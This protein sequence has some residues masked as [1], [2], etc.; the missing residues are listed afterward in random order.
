MA[1]KAG[2]LGRVGWLAA[3]VGPLGIAI[4]VWRHVATH[5]VAVTVVIGLAYAGVVAV[6]KFAAGIIRVLAARWRDQL[7][8]SLDVALQRRISRFGRRYRQFVLAGLRFTD[9]KGLATVGPFTPELD[10]VFVDVSLVSRPPHKI[11]PGLLDD[12]VVDAAGRHPLDD[13]INRPVPAVLAV[14]GGPGSGKTTLLRHTARDVCLKRTRSKARKRRL[15]VLLYLRDHVA[16]IVANPDVSI[17]DLIRSTLGELK[18]GEPKGW[19]EER[20]GSGECVVLLD[21]LDEVARQEDRTRVATWA[22]RQIRQHPGNDYV[23]T[24]RPYGYRVA[25]VAGAHVLAVC[26]LTDVQIDRFVHRWY[27]AVE[28]HSTGARDES[29]TARA[30][31]EADDLLRRLEEVPALRDLTVNPLLLTMI[32][33]VHR[34][35]GALPGSRAELYAEICQVM[36]WRRQEAKNLP[37]NLAGDKKEQ[38]LRGLA[39]AMMERRV[40][41]LA[42]GDVLAEIRPALRRLAG[43]ITAEDFLADV[44][45]NGLL[46]ERD[47]ELYCFV[48]PTFQEYLAAAHIRDK[49]LVRVL[50]DAVSDPWWREATL[51]YA[52]HADADP[53]IKA[54]LSSDSVIALALAFDCADQDSEIAVDLREQLD[55]MLAAVSRPDTTSERRRLIAGVLLTRHLHDQ[56]RTRDGRRICVRPITAD[57]YQ[58]FLDDT[59]TPAPDTRPGDVAT[60]MAVGMRASDAA[61]FVQWANAVT[62]GATT[63]NLPG[64]S[65]LRDP[66]V[67]ELLFAGSH[68]IQVSAVWIQSDRIL[69]PADRTTP[70]AQRN[71]PGPDLFIAGKQHPYRID[72][73]MLASYLYGDI[74]QS[75]RMLGRILAIRSAVGVITLAAYLERV[76]GQGVA[77]DLNTLN[78][79]RGRACVRDLDVLR[80]LAIGRDLGFARG[81]HP[82]V[83]HVSDLEIAKELELALNRPLT[84]D[85][86]CLTP[87]HDCALDLA[88][89]LTGRLDADVIF[90]TD[91]YRILY[92]T[93]ALDTTLSRALDI[94][95]D[96]GFV[97]ARVMGRALSKALSVTLRTSTAQW[98]SEFP[99][100][101]ANAGGVGETSYVVS[102]DTLSGYISAATQ[103]VFG[104][105]SSAPSYTPHSARF[106]PWAETVARRLQLI[107]RPVWERREVL[108]S[109]VAATIRVAALCLAGEA[110]SLNQHLLGDKFRAVAAG[111]TVLERRTTGDDLATEAIVLSAE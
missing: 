82:G 70:G 55:G 20:L 110:D 39:F 29:I 93:L 106:S 111:I 52:A 69:A 90:D 98:Y 65:A 41:D 49:G 4:V 58:L 75:P 25:G 43:R 74:S 2:W 22:E 27:L 10:E 79:S 15:P 46:V 77:Q 62:G 40:S 91:R 92:H 84:R 17:A 51:L 96:L 47:T 13:F 68:T 89:A 107:A 11:Q 81:L 26:A 104:Y 3:F 42:R 30:L 76:S 56:H 1:N 88:N 73:A 32:A 14:V 61:A 50:V 44:G 18:T 86:S 54:C 6:G 108:S 5:H 103:A 85:L 36:L 48:H 59:Q 99:A 33:N 101:L 53:I 37:V 83:V 45:S 38:L 8:D 19:F 23:I 12:P 9:L 100:A 57:L 95:T 16:A 72:S 71:N 60:G 102:M 63:Y 80:E 64:S 66:A 28:R 97:Y 21:G 78:L 94:S 7:A 34:Y 31:A 35:R 87:A 24:S 105:D 67:G 109:H